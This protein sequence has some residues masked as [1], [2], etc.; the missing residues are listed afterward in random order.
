MSDLFN[1]LDTVAAASGGN[2]F[3]DPVTDFKLRQQQIDRRR[4]LALDL[5]AK[6]MQTDG[7]MVGNIYVAKNPWQNFLESAFGSGQSA[8]ADADEAKLALQQRLQQQDF[9]NRFVRAKDTPTSPQFGHD[10][11]HRGNLPD[12]PNGPTRRE[13]LMQA[14]AN[15]LRTTLAREFMKSDEDRDYRA[16]QAELN[17]LAREQEKEADRKARSDDLKYRMTTPNVNVHMPQAPRDRFQIIAD[18]DGSQYRVNL[19]TGEK[20]PLGLVKPAGAKGAPGEKALTEA[21]GNAYL[22]GTRADQAHKVLGEVGTDYSPMKVS[23]AGAMDKVPGV[24]VGAN[25]VL[26]DK[27]QKVAQA[28]RDFVNAVLRK[29]SGA[30]IAQSEF[31][32]ARKQYF[33]QPGDSAAVVAQKKA[34]RET[35]IKGLAKI[36]GPQG[37]DIGKPTPAPQAAVDYLRQHPEQSAAFKAKYGYLPQGF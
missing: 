7:Q 28:Q 17:R 1:D 20:T 23:I 32:N 19:D 33:P 29:E 24:N 22:F 13:L 16:Q 15:G 14:E 3:S 30:A 8:A 12:I 35:A 9:N 11:V 2:V 37:A 31:D 26:T 21:Q 36:V 25:A 10:A 18:A 34:N 6:G 4:K 5:V 27:E